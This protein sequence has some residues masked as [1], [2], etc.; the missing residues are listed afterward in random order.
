M[1]TGTNYS[2]K[3]RLFLVIQNTFMGSLDLIELEEFEIPYECYSLNVEGI[4]L[5]EVEILTE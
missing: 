1:P 4:G 2:K 5:L 3:Q